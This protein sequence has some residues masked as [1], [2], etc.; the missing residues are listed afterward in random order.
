MRVSDVI[1]GLAVCG[2]VVLIGMSLA[3]EDS[4]D[5]LAD[6][7][8][9]ILVL[10]GSGT[11]DAPAFDT[12]VATDATVATEGTDATPTDSTDSTTTDAPAETP[13][14]ST[15]PPSS[16]P[17]TSTTV[18][19]ISDDLKPFVA[20]R[21]LNGGAGPGAA[22]DATELLAAAGFDPRAQGDASIDVAVTTVL[23][24]PDRRSDALTVNEVIGAA[25]EN[26]RE[27]TP[28]DPNWAEYGAD[29]HV[30]VVLGPSQ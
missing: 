5:A 4:P 1:G 29:L 15:P 26:V 30:L 3:D 20:V 16:P 10:N 18:P 19:L 23:Y 21:V 2:V 24:A 7:P 8:T 22:T 6:D 25:P 17:P 27:A 12:T 28:D 14:A 11:T 13:P 9:T